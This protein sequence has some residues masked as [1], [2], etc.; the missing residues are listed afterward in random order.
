MLKNYLRCFSEKMIGDSPKNRENT[1]TKNISNK[2]TVKHTLPLQNLNSNMQYI[3]IRNSSP[4]Q[5]F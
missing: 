1:F 5:N 4:L 2:N 3:Q